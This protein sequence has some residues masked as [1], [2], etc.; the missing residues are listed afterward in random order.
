MG[1][2]EEIESLLTR[3]LTLQAGVAASVPGHTFTLQPSGTPIKLRLVEEIHP[4]EWQPC[5]GMQQQVAYS[6]FPGL[7]ALDGEGTRIISPARVV[8]QSVEVET[9]AKKTLEP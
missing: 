1:F 8:S 3:A 2:K 4:R 5:D 9:D 7:T 6:V